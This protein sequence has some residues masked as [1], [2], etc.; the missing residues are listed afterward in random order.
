MMKAGARTL[1]AVIP[2][3]STFSRN[4]ANPFPIRL[5]SMTAEIPLVKSMFTLSM[6]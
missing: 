3:R 4:T 1:C 6:G 2:E 5:G